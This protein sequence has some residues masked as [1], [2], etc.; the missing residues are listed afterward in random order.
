MMGVGRTFGRVQLGDQDSAGLPQ[1]PDD[2]GIFVGTEILHDVHAAG[3]R[4]AFHPEQ[5]L[6]ADRNAVKRAAPESRCDFRIRA[7]RLLDRGVAK[8]DEDR[9]QARLMLLNALHQS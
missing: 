2:G 7:A 9:I 6:D 4:Q 1:S 5:V 3:R 8:Q